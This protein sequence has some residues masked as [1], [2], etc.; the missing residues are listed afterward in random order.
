MGSH[1]EIVQEDRKMFMPRLGPR[2]TRGFCSVNLSIFKQGRL[3]CKLLQVMTRTRRLTWR[4]Q[5]WVNE[6]ITGKGNLAS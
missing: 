1:T 6:Q 3:S 2:E 4:V 5:S